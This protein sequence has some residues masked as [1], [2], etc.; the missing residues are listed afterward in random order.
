MC[1]NH[2]MFNNQSD[3]DGLLTFFHVNG[4]CV[5]VNVFL[6]THCE[7]FTVHTVK[8]AASMFRTFVMIRPD[9]TTGGAHHHKTE[10]LGTSQLRGG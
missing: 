5:F 10:P 1:E 9:D 7:L 8:H 2:S 6:K 3:T 4:V